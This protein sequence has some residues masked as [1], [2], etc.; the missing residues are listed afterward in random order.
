MDTSCIVTRPSLQ[1]PGSTLLG[2]VII[3]DLVDSDLASLP[4]APAL[5]R[6][7]LFQELQAI[8]TGKSSECLGSLVPDHLSLETVGIDEDGL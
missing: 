4:D 8:H 7:V 5:I 2:K 1:L 6:L 3:F